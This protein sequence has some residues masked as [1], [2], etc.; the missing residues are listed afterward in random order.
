M[1]LELED[2]CIKF[3]FE[4]NMLDYAFICL[5]TRG[6]DNFHDLKYWIISFVSFI[7][8]YFKYKIQLKDKKKIWENPEKFDNIKHNNADFVS[9]NFAEALKLDKLNKVLTDD[10]Y[11]LINM[12]NQIRNKF[13]HYSLNSDDYMNSG[14]PTVIKYNDIVTCYE[15]LKRCIMDVYVTIDKYIKLYFE[16]EYNLN[17]DKIKNYTCPYK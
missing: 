15:I 5:N 13:I 8:L 6:F 11:K 3:S 17:Y 14:V 12:F 2:R 4:A 7:E 16:N 1:K 10:E 9:I